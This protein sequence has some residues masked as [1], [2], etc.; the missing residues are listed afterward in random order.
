M[1]CLL[2]LKVHLAFG[3]LNRQVFPNYLLGALQ[4]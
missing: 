4:E 1:V 3:F 2:K